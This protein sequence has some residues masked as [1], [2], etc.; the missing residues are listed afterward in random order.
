MQSHIRARR[1]KCK[2]TQTVWVGADRAGIGAVFR[3]EQLDGAASVL[4]AVAAIA[5]RHRRLGGG[6][7]DELVRTCLDEIT[8][9]GLES[10]E[11][12]VVITARIDKR[13]HPSQKMARRNGF[14]HTGMLDEYQVWQKALLL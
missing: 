2:P 10:G 11:P 3:L 8:A 4:L 13:N 1:H 6:V 12:E 5:M 7:A 9:Q 14:T